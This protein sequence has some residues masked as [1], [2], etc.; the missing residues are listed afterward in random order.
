MVALLEVACL[1]LKV[2]STQLEGNI[3]LWSWRSLASRSP[4]LRYCPSGRLASPMDTHPASKD[5]DPNSPLGRE[6]NNGMNISTTISSQRIILQHSSERDVIIK[7]FF[8]FSQ[9]VICGN[10]FVFEQGNVS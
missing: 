9:R 5:S 7:S 8:G 1:S 4:P 10:F 3:A 2:N 6:I